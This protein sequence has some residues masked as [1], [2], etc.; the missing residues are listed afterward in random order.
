[1]KMYI[2]SL[3]YYSRLIESLVSGFIFLISSVQCNHLPEN[4]LKYHQ[5]YENQ[6]IHKITYIHLFVISLLQR[7]RGKLENRG[8]EIKANYSSIT[9]GEELGFRF[10]WVCVCIK[11]ASCL[12]VAS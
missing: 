12:S 8:R 5:I 6:Y 4:Q 2:K 11:C 9:D 7:R 1:M 10:Y 3:R